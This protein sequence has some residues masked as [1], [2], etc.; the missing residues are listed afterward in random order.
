[1]KYSFFLFL[2]IFS[3]LNL[4][5][6]QAVSEPPFIDFKQ[7]S[8]ITEYS[9]SHKRIWGWSRDSKVAYSDD[10]ETEGRGGSIITVVIFDLVNDTI[11]WENSL[12][13]YSFWGEH[14]L[15][16]YK[17]AYN[18]FILD[19]INI[20]GLNGI[21]F[22]QTEYFD[23]PIRH[24]AQTVNIT[25]EKTNRQGMDKDDLIYFGRIGS[26]KILAENRRKQKTI[27]EKTFCMAAVDIFVCGY[28][29]SP[30]ENRA[31]VVVGELKRVFE[32]Y[33]IDEYI[34]IGCHLSDGFR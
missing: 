15:E 8:N 12:D 1:M 20:C 4:F 17:I 31:L 10:K 22:I 2:F 21:E 3:G 28:F 27:Y 33:A 32:G 16:Q 19:F 6:Q 18:N 34:F 25:V 14:L 29:V 23:L 26:Y 11:L 5:A 30:F 7:Y 13:T 24:N 9:N